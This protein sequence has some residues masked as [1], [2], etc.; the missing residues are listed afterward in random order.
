[1]IG[2]DSRTSP[3][4]AIPLGDSRAMAMLR[5]GLGSGTTF[6]AGAITINVN[7]N[8]SVTPS[9]AQTIG[10]NVASGFQSVLASQGISTAVKVA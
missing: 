10:K 1:M 6:E 4:A 3:E 9:Q 7:V 8:G 5:E 2:E